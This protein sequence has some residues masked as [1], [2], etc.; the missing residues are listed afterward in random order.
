MTKKI[1]FLFFLTILLFLVIGAASASD[2]NATDIIQENQDDA[3]ANADLNGN[4]SNSEDD[5]LKTSDEKS[6]ELKADSNAT[7]EVLK[8]STQKT[9]EVISE[10]S[11][12]SA[13][14][15]TTT[16]TTS[17]VVSNPTKVTKTK[18]I[19]KT[20]ANFAKNGQKYKMFLTDGKGKAVAYKNVK[21]TLN[22]KTYVKTTS[23]AGK[24]TIKVSSKKSYVKIKLKCAGDTDH[25]SF[26][27]TI[28]VYIK[29]LYIN[30]GNTKLLTNGYLRVYLE[31]SKSLISK[32]TLKITVGKKA[33]TKKTNS[34]GFAVIKP[35][36][37][38][39]KYKVTVKLGKY[40]AN[41]DV[42]CIKGN[43]LNPLKSYIP[44]VNGVPDVDRMPS[45]FV[46]GDGNAKYTLLKS[47]YKETIKRDSYCL[48]L[49]DKLPKYTFFKTKASP[50]T[51]H[52]LKREKWNVIERAL[53]TKLVKAYKYSY[54]PK[55]IT[56][57]LKGK[58]Y[59]YPIVRDI[60]NTGYNCG[61]TSASVCS[62]AL[63][64]YYSERYFQI[65]GACT[66]GMN[67]PD[68]KILLE[69]HNFKTHYF[70][71]D[72]SFNRAMNELKTGAVLI[73]YLP[74]H[75]ISIVDISPNGK[76][77]LVSNSYGSYNVGSKEVPTNWVSI[78]YLKSKFA[79][80]GLVVK[81]DYKLS[82]S[83]KNQ[84][85]NYYKSMGTKWTARNVNERIPNVGL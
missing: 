68:I 36:V 30:I 34:E 13:I 25:Y 49:Y 31:G 61:P 38:A 19:L 14:I 35:Q 75:Y 64:N 63:K 26:A 85:K 55:S 77:V 44:T 74:N 57:S 80:I 37:T 45:N 23:K 59:T 42:T 53:N 29:N 18:I 62:Q 78:S 67:I 17:N 27:K 48:F 10:I 5:V 50:K 46:M 47:Q 16:K 54:W 11:S 81:L 60:Q 32:K 28:K 43:V 39:K 8:A 51:Y 71:D 66:D 70:Y 33:F 83:Q 3:I 2:D 56:V 65:E 72:S 73:A 79:G 52:I 6:D 20:N 84:V 22:G 12:K 58:S 15:P 24:I 21:V 69:E 40:R 7:Q 41:K 4:D 9:D 1:T 76:K 82:S